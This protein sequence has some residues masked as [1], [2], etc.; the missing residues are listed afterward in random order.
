M[1]DIIP[2]VKIVNHAGVSSVKDG[3]K[4]NLYSQVEREQKP[5]WIR[6]TANHANKNFELIKS[7]VN[8]L[9]LSTV[10]EEAKCPTFQNAGRGEQL[11]LWLW[12]TLVQ[13]LAN[14]V[15]LIQEIPKDGL[16][17]MSRE[18]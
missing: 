13:E 11:H 17:Q 7:K 15:R 2:T 4:G 10:C 12:V 1:K 9:Q 8:N 16:M 6:I 5:K 14:F 18:R 3:M